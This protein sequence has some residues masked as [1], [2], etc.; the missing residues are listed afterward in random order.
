M[1]VS[2]LA[3][4]KTPMFSRRDVQSYYVFVSAWM[5]KM[6]SILSKE[7]RMDKFAEDLTNRCSVFIQV[8]PGGNFFV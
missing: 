2:F 6:E 5:M 4:L 3:V 8:G 7:Q 1:G